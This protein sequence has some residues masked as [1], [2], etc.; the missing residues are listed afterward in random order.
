MRRLLPVLASL[1]LLALPSAAQAYTFYEWDAA[2][3]PAGIAVSGGGLSVT[4][5][6][7]GSIGR[8]SLGG[9]QSAPATIAGGASRPAAL[10]AGPGD[11][12]LWFVDPTNG[13]IG[14]TDAGVGPVT[15]A[16][17][18]GGAPT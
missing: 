12:N 4:L 5:N 2:G 7:A 18:V 17:A 8:V 1:A 9:V 10:A 15:I 11:G 13:R 14:R 16:T 3:T 6:Q